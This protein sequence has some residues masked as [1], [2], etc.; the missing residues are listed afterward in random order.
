MCGGAGQSSDD[1]GADIDNKINQMKVSLAKLQSLQGRLQKA[2]IVKLMT[3]AANDA[4]KE[5]NQTMK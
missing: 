4:Y 1:T 3:S 2:E 5:S